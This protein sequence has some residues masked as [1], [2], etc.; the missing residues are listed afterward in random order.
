MDSWKCGRGICV[1]VTR[2]VF[3][4]LMTFGFIQTSNAGDISEE[5]LMAGLA[6]R[7]ITPPI[8][9]PLSGYGGNKRRI[10][11]F[12]IFNKYPYAT[13]FK[14]SVGIIDPIQA[15]ALVL[16]KGDKKIVF[17]RLDVI[18]VPKRFRDDIVDDLDHLGFGDNEVF[19][20]ATHTHAG[21]GTLSR[22]FLWKIIA[23][24]FFQ[25]R[26]YVAMVADVVATIE[27]AYDAM[28]EADLYS[29]QFDITNIQ[30]NRRKR[31]GHF[32]PT[33]NGLMVSS[34][35]GKWLG[36]LINLAIHGI[37]LG[38]ENLKY[39]AD[40]MGRMESHFEARLKASNGN[41]DPVTVAFI[42]GAEGDV[43]PTHG[44]LEG[45]EWTGNAFADQAVEAMSN[46]RP[47]RP[48]WEVKMLEVKIGKPGL[49]LKACVEQKTLQALIFRKLRI[50]LGWWMPKKAKIWSISLD[51]MVFMTWPG[52][53]TTDLGIVMKEI[54][55]TAGFVQPWV[56]GLT[57][58]HLS[59]F[60]S[61]DEEYN[62]GY[63]VCGSFYG[64]KGSENL[65]DG[66][67][68]ML[69]GQ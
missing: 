20:S 62:L 47:I 41:N 14:P 56:F 10:F 4:I 5:P 55:T 28:V 9:V 42:N 29:F 36:G 2:M 67:R 24:D 53:P 50:F 61:R 3:L 32:D 18:G 15:K 45:M 43:S 30:R 69:L 64:Y 58:D 39:S 22:N 60:T 6:T 23:A 31:P 26:I 19:I 33:A 66:F 27:K 40:V 17:V 65:L 13:L 63:E 51:D 12:D 49:N 1:N 68:T 54:A 16:K 37:A 34:K 52:E 11:P 7:D 21:P 59:Y 57:N 48:D 8:G 25:K 46:L 35:D 44:G 38:I